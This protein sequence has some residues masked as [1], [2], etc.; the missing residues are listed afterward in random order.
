M[1]EKSKTGLQILQIAIGLG[2]LGDVLLRHMPWGLNVLLFNLAFAAGMVVLLWR[3]K[4]DYLTSQTWALIGAQVF[5]AA[6]FVWRDSPELHVADSVAIIAILSVLFVPKLKIPARIAGVFHYI[7]GFLWSAL[8][9]AFATV[10]LLAVDIQWKGENRSVGAKNAIAVVRGLLLVTPL[11]LIFGGLFI[12][13][14]AAY[15]GLVQR[16]FN[17]NLDVVF[18]H[19]LIFAFFSWFSAGYLRGITLGGEP[20]FTVDPVARTN[21]PHEN[22][23][24][25]SSGASKVDD[26]KNDNA[27]NPTALPDNVSILEHIN[28]SDPPNETEEAKEETKSEA[29]TEPKK[30]WQW[31]NVDNTLLPSAF[32]VGTI[33]VGIILGLMNLLF[34]SFVIVQIPYLFG[35]MDLVQNTPDFKLAEYARR[36]FG[37]LVAVSAL[38][39]PVLLIGHWLVRKDNSFTEKLFR[40]LASVQIVLL[41]IIMA[42]AVQRL[43][44]LTGNLGYGMTTVRLY[45]MIFMIWLGVVFIWFASTVLRGYRRYFAWGALWSAFL[46]LAAT[47]FLNPNEFILRTNIR[48]MQQ[49]RE[50]DARYN[51]GLGADATPVLMESFSLYSEEDAEIVIRQLERQQCRNKEGR[52]LRDWNFSRWQAA[53][54]MS[55]LDRELMSK[56]GGCADS[57]EENFS[58]E[59]SE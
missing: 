58:Y 5:F 50:F 48:L 14:D 44:L 53:R 7:V 20:K 51:S 22:K 17:V 21:K 34:L 52:D 2:I 28:K 4:R 45:P 37:E 42:S 29:K 32:T 19:F 26:L 33:E 3:R 56:A 30:S 41:F 46:V 16:V 38:V 54:A 11:I 1:N 23:S 47:H 31:A 6:M 13:A 10:G 57:P 18:S 40:G 25:E 24:A 8:N 9:A 15:E 49:G 36:G 39:L 27:E 12:A 55:G 43:V 59:G 35:G